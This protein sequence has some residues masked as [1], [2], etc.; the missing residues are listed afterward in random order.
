MR[1]PGSVL[2]AILAILATSPA[3]ANIPFIQTL[4]APKKAGVVTFEIT[5][6]PSP[7]PEARALLVTPMNKT[8]DATRTQL[9]GTVTNGAPLVAFRNET[10]RNIRIT[11][12]QPSDA[13]R[14]QLCKPA[15][16]TNLK[17]YIPLCEPKG[18][19]PPQLCR[20]VGAALEVCD[21]PECK[22]IKS[23]CKGADCVVD[24]FR[25]IEQCGCS[26]TKRLASN[27]DILPPQSTLAIN[28]ITRTATASIPQS[29][30]SFL[31]VQESRRDLEEKIRARTKAENVDIRILPDAEMKEKP[32]VIFDALLFSDDN[33]RARTGQKFTFLIEEDFDPTADNSG[34]IRPSDASVLTWTLGPT[35]G[36][37]SIV[38]DTSGPP[39]RVVVVALDNTGVSSWRYQN[40]RNPA[41]INCNREGK[42]LGAT[43]VP[44]AGVLFHNRTLDRT[45]SVSITLPPTAK[46]SQADEASFNCKSG[47]PC[48]VSRTVPPQNTVMFDNSILS[49][50][51]RSVITF[52]VALLGEATTL[53]NSH[54]YL[55]LDPPVEA[56]KFQL[57]EP[58]STTAFKTKVSLAGRID[59]SFRIL[60]DK[61]PNPLGDFQLCNPDTTNYP[62]S[63]PILCS[64]NPYRGG[65]TQQY[66]AKGTLQA[67]PNLGNRADGSVTLAFRSGTFGASTIDKVG[68]DQYLINV[69][70]INGLSL[71]FGKGDFALPSD[72]IAIAESGEGFVYGYRVFSLGHLVTRESAKGTADQPNRDK[73]DWF[74]Q[75]RSL[76]F[77]LPVLRSLDA[78]ALRGEDKDSGS[79][80]WTQGVELFLALPGKSAGMNSEGVTAI[81]DSLDGSIAAYKSQRTW[82]QSSACWVANPR[83]CQ[84]GRGFVGLAKLNW[85]PQ[86]DFTL[87][88]NAKTTTPHTLS[89]SFGY[90]TGDRPGTD[91]DEGYIGETAGFTPDKLFFSTF[92][93]KM[94][95][96]LIRAVPSGLAN[97][98]YLA[99][100]YTDNEHTLFDL[101]AS[102]LGVEADVNSRAT[103]ISLSNTGL[104]FPRN[105]SRQA[106]R[107]VDVTFKIEAPKGVTFSL[108]SAYLE[109]GSAFSDVI[110]KRA[111][112]LVATVSL[113]L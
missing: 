16:K 67:L 10:M 97:K 77:E 22:A 18:D 46:L 110:T 91:V 35:G 44:P 7:L 79:I 99:I 26:V 45:F 109:P 103:I 34:K 14:P 60:P 107:E 48:V 2:C 12:Q 93:P 27:S 15:C 64:A 102:A 1:H 73:K 92:L 98:R 56:G 63:E 24:L 54:A 33:G 105:G 19:L 51:P 59:P 57:E 95:T 41:C 90:G 84:R 23:G 38:P 108:D 104:I 43:D 28:E 8:P 36:C 32:T 50:F 96:D 70:G 37:T 58:Q 74:L 52:D 85:T 112:L 53:T 75:I 17:D 86:I 100:S 78:I 69:Y 65:V 11:L 30:A 89:A 13:P 68:I 55:S 72:S 49:N 42:A 3:S 25:V 21:T 76:P 88:Q 40:P 101:V 6:A 61:L 82:K 31:T 29:Q 80:Y 20:P 47:K 81:F 113:A 87:G 111:W 83:T 71:K 66:K 5:E 106:A 39:T 94:N 62:K 4:K 9:C